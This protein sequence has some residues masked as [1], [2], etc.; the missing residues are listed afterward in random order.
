MIRSRLDSVARLLATAL[1]I[2]VSGALASG[3][4]A[5]P[6]TV[7]IAGI[8]APASHSALLTVDHTGPTTIFTL[9]NTSTDGSAL[10]AF[11]FNLPVAVS[12]ANFTYS[13]SG[14]GGNGN[15]DAYFNTSE[16]M[17]NSTGIFDLGLSTGNGTWQGGQTNSGVAVGGEGIFTFTWNPADFLDG[18]SS[19]DFLG[20]LTNQDQPFKVRFQGGNMGSDVGLST[21]VI[22]LPAAAWLLIGG[23]GGLGLVARRRKAAA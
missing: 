1:A 22:P 4:N 6:V 9:E 2:A 11:A 16:P 12:P 20:F 8:N 14:T 7:G 17:P 15:W 19:A 18:Y 23:L 10:T 3:A 21:G 5:A 13:V